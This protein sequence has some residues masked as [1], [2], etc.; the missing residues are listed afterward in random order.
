VGS[1]EPPTYIP[2]MDSARGWINW[3]PDN[4]WIAFGSGHH[5]EMVSPDGKIRKKIPS[6][7]TASPYGYLLVWSRDGGTIYVASSL[8]RG[9]RVHA[10]DVRSGRSRKI[11]EYGDDIEFS[12]P[13]T[14]TLFGCLSP[15]GKSIITTCLDFKSDVWILDGLPQR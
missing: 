6:P 11:A 3:S 12:M 15:D 8:G 7:E 10:V 4:K 14:Y 13:I 5:I 2:A 9:A 1:Q